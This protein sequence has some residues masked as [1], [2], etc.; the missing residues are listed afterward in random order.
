M[1]TCLIKREDF[2]LFVF[3]SL[4]GRGQGGVRVWVIHVNPKIRCD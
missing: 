4:Q 1:K 2:N 3:V